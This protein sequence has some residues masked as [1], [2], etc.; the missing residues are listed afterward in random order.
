MA[1]GSL[2]KSRGMSPNENSTTTGTIAGDPEKA[3][4]TQNSH[5][6]QTEPSADSVRIDAE[7]EKR[8]IRKLDKRLISLVFTL[9]MH[10]YLIYISKFLILRTNKSRSPGLPGS[11]EYWKCENR[12]SR[13]RS[14]HV[15]FAVP[16]APNHL[17][18]FVHSIRMVCSHVES[19]AAAHV[20]YVLRLG[21]G[22]HC[23]SS[24]CDQLVL[25]DDGR[26]FL[27]RIL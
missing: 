18:H 10:R 7:I 11:L 21:M 9:C 22:T 3:V 17:L 4:A 20:G 1:L 26:A 27:S 14:Q 12:R 2:F 13:H 8:V 19:R 5:G 6:A 23:D 15:V 16:M 25:W 24:K